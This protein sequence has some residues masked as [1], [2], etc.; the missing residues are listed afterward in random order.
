MSDSRRETLR[1]A[2]HSIPAEVDLLYRDDEVVALEPQAVKVIR[3]LA[4]HSDR[5]VPK[6]ELLDALWPDVFT[7][8]GVLKRAI[9]QARRALGDTPSSARFIATYHGRGYRFVASVDRT[10][11]AEP[12][13]S[14]MPDPDFDQLTGRELE[15]A[16]LSS[17]LRNAITGQPRPV[18]ILGDAGIG[19][20]Q[21]ARRF[22]REISSTGVRTL[23]VRFFDYGGSQL[24]PYESF[25]DLL[26]RTAGEGSP[27]NPA[28]DALDRIHRRW[29]VDLSNRSSGGPS[30]D[31]QSAASLGDSYGMIVTIGRCIQ[32]LSRERPLVLIA[33]DLQWATEADLDLVSWLLRAPE[34][35]PLLL[36]GI[37]RSEDLA[38]TT[39]PIARWMRKEAGYRSFTTLRLEP[40]TRERCRDAVDAVF[41]AATAPVIPEPQLDSIYDLCRGNPYFL[42]ETLRLFISDGVLVADRENHRW[43]WTGRDRVR[44]P[45]SLVLLAEARLER[46]DPHVRSL[47]DAAAVI[48]DEFRIPTLSRIA[49]VEEREAEVL[50]ERGVAEGV[51]TR[52][53]L[54]PGEDGR[55]YHTLIRRTVYD[56]LSDWQRRSLHAKAAR[57]LEE[58]YAGELDRVADA[59]SVHYEAAGETRLTFT[60]S[61]RA[62]QAAS[63]RWEWRQ[64]L[65]AVE[66]A[67]RAAER[68]AGSSNRRLSAEEDSALALALGE[69]LLSLGRLKEADEVV[70]RALAS[71]DVPRATRGDLLLLRGRAQTALSRYREAATVLQE[72]IEAFRN[73]G[74]SAGEHRALIE[75]GGVEAARGRYDD[76]HELLTSALE[77]LDPRS[78]LASLAFGI[79]GWAT[80]L[81]G[82]Y[83]RGSELLSRALESTEPAVNVRRR[84]LLLRRLHWI[85]LS[86]G[87]YEEAI[88]LALR[89]RNE[90]RR[91]GDVAGEAKSN[92]GLGQARIGQGRYDEAEEYLRQTLENLGEIGD[93]HCE[94]ETL[95]LLGRCLVERGD[96]AGAEPLLL[97]ALTMVRQIGDRDDEFRIL[98]DLAR[99]EIRI[100]D[101][102]KAFRVAGEA[103][104]IASELNNRDGIALAWCEMARSELMQGELSAAL[105][106]AREA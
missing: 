11:A 21:L 14:G 63:G 40:L 25:I 10:V 13:R 105:D 73:V 70:E 94:A 78:Q 92:M 88:D 35:D 2:S 57:A 29:G 69:T 37:L 8:D 33:D 86:R 38:S 76:A 50:I 102:A 106:R 61:M 55:F 68:L 79:L 3:Y 89:A 49:K 15:L 43:R 58:V 47:I 66:R 95:W 7:T 46:L 4:H 42:M 54:T 22:E 71:S 32:E 12:E 87:K 81:Q 45:D 98:T 31:P 30:V 59:L 17:E 51:L 23:Y 101:C 83:E 6:E 74:S 5:V 34:G 64:A 20:T 90:F 39:R 19:K 28:T 1:F 26:A 18:M 65:T 16:I 104:G 24:A 96:C 44:L 91:I 100:K 27:A 77:R 80:A 48:G 60:T 103:A 62:W 72:S 85:E 82:D 53:A 9:S 93:T 41:G 97:N 99:M 52:R 67:R 75:L 56:R 84:A 36:V